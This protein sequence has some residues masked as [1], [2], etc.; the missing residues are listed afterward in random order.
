MS[1]KPAIRLSD[2]P[3]GSSVRIRYIHSRP[4]M[5]ARLRE[6]GFCEDIVVRCIMKSHGNLICEILN[7]RIGLDGKLA[8][9]IMV[10]PSE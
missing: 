4:E 6:M 8:D 5:S 7:T 1:I 9:G 3:A 10:S 2:A